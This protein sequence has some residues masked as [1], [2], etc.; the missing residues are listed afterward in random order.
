M[1]DEEYGKALKKFHKLSNRHIL[2]IETDMSYSDVMKISSIR[3]S[4]SGS[5]YKTDAQ[6][7]FRLR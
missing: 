2:T 3:K 1:T 5:L 4:V 6:A 7:D